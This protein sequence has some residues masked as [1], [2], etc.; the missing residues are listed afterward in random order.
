M[1]ARTFSNS[2]LDKVL[3][4]IRQ[5]VVLRQMAPAVQR[6]SRRVQMDANREAKVV[7]SR[8]G[9]GAEAERVKLPEQPK[10]LFFILEREVAEKERTEK[11]GKGVR[12]GGSG[13]TAFVA[14]LSFR[15]P[16]CLPELFHFVN[17]SANT[18]PTF[19]SC[20]T[21][22]RYTRHRP[23][24]PLGE[25]S[26]TRSSSS[27]SSSHTLASLN[28]SLSTTSQFSKLSPNFWRK[29]QGE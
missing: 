23:K 29:S 8:P 1:K 3:D 12:G 20:D 2:H 15:I 5:S 25:R 19:S 24:A 7:F 14:Y 22:T 6:L 18:T 10:A 13:Y 11:G 27:P 21:S 16:G 9:A 26:P 28:A 17:M 4:A